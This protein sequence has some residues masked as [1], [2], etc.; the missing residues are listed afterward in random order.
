MPS[1][2]TFPLDL[3]STEVVVGVCI[4]TVKFSNTFSHEKPGKTMHHWKSPER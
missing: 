4:L 1:Q 3:T 2:P